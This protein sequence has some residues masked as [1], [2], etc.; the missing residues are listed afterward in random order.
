MGGAN[1]SSTSLLLWRKPGLNTC[2]LPSPGKAKR[3]KLFSSNFLFARIIHSRGNY[4]KKQIAKKTKKE[5]LPAITPF[6]IFIYSHYNEDYTN[7][8]LFNLAL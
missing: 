3:E 1:T 8:E 7:R 6:L 5:L 4:K 2:V